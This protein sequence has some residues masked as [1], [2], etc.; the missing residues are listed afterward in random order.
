MADIIDDPDIWCLAGNLGT[1]RMVVVSTV[2]L[3]EIEE[4]SSTKPILWKRVPF[5]P[6]SAQ[7]FFD[8]KKSDKKKGIRTDYAML[9]GSYMYRYKIINVS[10]E[11]PLWSLYF[12][13]S[14]WPSLSRV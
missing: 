4:V 13:T 12:V 1:R 8:R 7:E 3:W 5:E 10:G 14:P 6:K 11:C 2:S 9:E